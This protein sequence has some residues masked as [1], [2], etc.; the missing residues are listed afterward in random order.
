MLPGLKL[1]KH[2]RELEYTCDGTFETLGIEK[3]ATK[4]IN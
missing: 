3:H 1:G 2:S 4:P